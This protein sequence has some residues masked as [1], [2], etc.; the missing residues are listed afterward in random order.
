VARRLALAAV[1]L[2]ALVAAPA[3]LAD[4]DVLAAAFV[5]TASV[6]SVHATITGSLTTQG[7]TIPLHATAAVDVT[8]RSAELSFRLANPGAA[9]GEPKAIAFAALV[10]GRTGALYLRF[11]LL[12]QLA[13]TKK[14]WLKID[15]GKRGLDLGSVL[16][17][18]PSQQLALACAL[19]GATRNLGPAAVGGVA[20]T[21]YRSRIDYQ[22]A[23]RCVPASMRA[24]LR[25]F[26]RQ[27]AGIPAVPID[28]YVDAQGYV[29]RTAI[30]LSARVAKTKLRTSLTVDLSGF[31]VPVHLQPPPPSQ[32]A[33]F[34]G[35]LSSILQPG[36]NQA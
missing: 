32:V 24:G 21:H 26:S 1:C 2:A 10:D 36:R 27:L 29:R 22:Q 13:K 6:H 35:A 28:A 11:P 33:D 18:D 25:R 31:D 17:A 4:G 23:A 15:L 14:P 30:D 8:T 16:Q 7:Q 9:A 19:T 5:K 20:T 3:A 34:A 12:A